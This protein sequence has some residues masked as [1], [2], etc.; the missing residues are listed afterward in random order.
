MISNNE[1]ARELLNSASQPGRREFIKKSGAGLAGFAMSMHV[2]NIITARAVNDDPINIGVIGCGGRGTG[3]ALDALNAATKIIYPEFGYHTESALEGARAQ[4]KNVKIIALADLFPDRIASCKR[5][6]E[7]VGMPVSQEMC[8]SGFDG[9]KALLQ[10]P[11]INYII[12]AEPP[13][14]RPMHLRACIEAGKNVFMEKPAGVDSAGVRSVIESGELAKQKGLAIGAGTQRRYDNAMADNVK[15]IQNGAIG[16]IRSGVARWLGG[17]IW[18]VEPKPEWTQMEAQLRNWNYYNWL[19]GDIIVEQF[20]HSI[21]LINWVLQ[22]TPLKAVGIGGRQVRTDPKLYGNVYDHFAVQYEYPNDITVYAL[23]RQI[24]GCTN[25][26]DDVII[27]SKGRAT[28]AYRTMGYTSSEGNWRF[29]GERNNPYQ[30]E[31][32]KLI[33]SIRSGNPI[34]EA[35]QIAESTLTAIMG[36]EVCYSGHEIDWETAMNLNQRQGPAEYKFGD[37]PVEPVPMPGK[38][39]YS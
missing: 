4:A 12:L 3:A 32:E 16:E 13:H 29:R 1:K 9:Y 37:N 10:V 7:K 38:Y 24:N 14:F 18:V 33:E 2:P 6:L 39:K 8:F 21:D 31:H 25:F 5:E 17:E 27:G 26:V 30:V 11:E 35:R 22:S 23:D 28:F 15:H 20:I 36:R 34:N 19:S